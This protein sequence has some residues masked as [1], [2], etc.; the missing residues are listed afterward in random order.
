MAISPTTETGAPPEVRLRD[1]RATSDPVSIVA[2][3]VTAQRREITRKSDGGRRPVLSGLLSDGTASVRFTWWDPPSEPIEKGEILRA[4]NVQVREWQGRIEV[5]FNWKSRVG[6]AGEA[7]LPNVPPESIPV[8]PLAELRAGDDGIRVVGRVLRVAPKTVSVGEERRLLH[9]GVVADSSGAIAFTA[10]SDF[11]LRPGEAIDVSGG[12]ARGFRGRPQLVLDE[13]S[14]V[15]RVP[16]EGLP[17]AETLAGGVPRTIADIETAGGGELLEVH[18]V[19]V[20]LLP[21]SGLVYRCSQCRR[22][23]RQGVCR[24]HGTVIPEP[25][26]RARLVLDDGTGALT[27][28]AGRPETERL[29]GRTLEECLREVAATSDPSRLEEHLFAATFGRRLVVRGRGSA[30]D[31]GVTVQPESIELAKPDLVARAGAIRKV[32]GGTTG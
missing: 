29:W 3:V 27:V 4:V 11:R 17:N 1:L 16:G 24:V 23:V 19:V 5:S 31:F 32:L 14:T 10:W 7:E 8:R 26:L 15:R 20:G 13:R 6:P 25:D 30:D 18:G 21:P 2:R 28:N 12:Y 9:E 22:A